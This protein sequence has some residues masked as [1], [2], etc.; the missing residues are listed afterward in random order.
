MGR[1]SLCQCKMVLRRQLVGNFIFSFLATFRSGGLH[2]H[3]ISMPTAK[4]NVKMVIRSV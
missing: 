3:T 4:Y 2:N 1:G